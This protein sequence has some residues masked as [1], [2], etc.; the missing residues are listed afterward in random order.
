ML[1]L[2][3]IRFSY[4]C[5]TTYQNE[6]G[7]CPIVL[8]IIFRSERRDI[9]TGLYCFKENWDK[10][11]SKVGKAAGTS[12]SLNQNLDLILRKATYSFD[13]LKFSGNAFTID[14]LVDKIKGKETR[15]TLLINFLDEGKLKMKKR[16][17]T[18][19]RRY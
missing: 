14:E 8:R 2:L 11:N 18:E 3:N 6:D 5:R 7:Q 15:P 10:K 16:V 9:F 12:G 1:E 13:E 19:I 17:G 4:L